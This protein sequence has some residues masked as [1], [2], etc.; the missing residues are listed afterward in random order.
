ATTLSAE[1]KDQLEKEVTDDSDRT[2]VLSFSP[3]GRRF[4]RRLAPFGDAFSS[5]F[6]E[7]IGQILRTYA[8]SNGTLTPFNELNRSIGDL[9]LDTMTLRDIRDACR[10]RAGCV[11]ANVDVIVAA[12]NEQTESVEEAIEGALGKGVFKT[13]QQLLGNQ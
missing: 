4:G 6:Q 1:Q 5:L 3:A 2:V 11:P 10:M 9:E 12:A 7:N 8:A 13:W